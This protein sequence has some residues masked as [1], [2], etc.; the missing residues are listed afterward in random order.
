M[1]VIALTLLTLSCVAAGE[2]VPKEPLQV[3]VVAVQ[4][5]N[6]GRSAKHFGEGLA[7]V[8]KAIKGLNYD[9][10]YKIRSADVPVP[11]GEEAKIFIDEQY[12]LYVTPLSVTEEGRI[13]LRARIMMKSKGKTIKALD[14]KLTMTPGSS[15]NLGGLRLK[16]GELI[17]VVSVKLEKR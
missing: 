11:Y 3:A 14:T 16:S 15:A 12:A 1:T 9:S 5:K 10:F 17:I 2:D 8:R 13:R 6:E 4:A 7:K